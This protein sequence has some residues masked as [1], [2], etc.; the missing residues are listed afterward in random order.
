MLTVTTPGIRV[1]AYSTGCRLLVI[2]LLCS[3]VLVSGCSR[4][5]DFGSGVVI[6]GPGII[7]IPVTALLGA[8]VIFLPR[9]HPLRR[10]FMAI[11]PF[12]LFITILFVLFN[13]IAYFWF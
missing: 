13:V 1:A 8:A 7:T 3:L 12:A 5:D 10:T 11:F 4:G 6:I 2:F 9:D